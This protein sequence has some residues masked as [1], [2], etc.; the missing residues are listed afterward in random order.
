[1]KKFKILISLTLIHATIS[2]ILFLKSFTYGMNSF[3]TGEFPSVSGKILELISTIFLCPLFY[4]LS[5][6]GGKGTH[7]IFPGLLGYIPLIINSIIWA[8][9]IY[10]IM[11]KLR[12][13]K[14]I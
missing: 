4:P 8:I 13:I 14:S 2:V 9:I 1:M 7:N 6:W 5:K 3:E 11:K 10:W 12:L